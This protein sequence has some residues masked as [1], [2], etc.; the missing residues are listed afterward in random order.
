M[1][2]IKGTMSYINGV[3]VGTFRHTMCI[4]SKLHCKS[5]SAT[6]QM[7]PLERCYQGFL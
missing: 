2:Y 3:E 6:P 5:K 4:I 1:K 7:N